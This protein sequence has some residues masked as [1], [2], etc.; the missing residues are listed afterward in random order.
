LPTVEAVRGRPTLY[1]AGPR[2]VQAYWERGRHEVVTS[3]KRDHADYGC[4][5]DMRKEV[6]ETCPYR[7]PSCWPQAL[8]RRSDHT[9][10]VNDL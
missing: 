5:H 10:E 7:A 3:T 9:R 8:T 2:P 1:R 4:S 6:T